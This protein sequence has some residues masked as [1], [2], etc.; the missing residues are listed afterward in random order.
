[1]RPSIMS[2]PLGLLAGW[3]HVCGVKATVHEL[4]YASKH[5]KMCGMVWKGRGPSV[6]TSCAAAPCWL[7]LLLLPLLPS[8]RF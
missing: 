3:W 6:H 5:T 8:R 7:L 4:S 2:A 1:M